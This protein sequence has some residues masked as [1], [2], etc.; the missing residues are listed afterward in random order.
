[1]VGCQDS[2]EGRHKIGTPGPWKVCSRHSLFL[3]KRMKK[4]NQDHYINAGKRHAKFPTVFY[5]FKLTY[6]DKSMRTSQKLFAIIF[7]VPNCC[8]RETKIDSGTS[9]FPGR[10]HFQHSCHYT[11]LCQYLSQIAKEKTRMESPAYVKIAAVICHS[12]S[13]NFINLYKFPQKKPSV[14]VWER[15]IKVNFCSLLA[16]KSLFVFYSYNFYSNKHYWT[17]ESSCS[18]LATQSPWWQYQH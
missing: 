8:F 16:A 14:C 12:Q 18:P 7:T 10:S 15:W 9:C 3:Q 11:V 1:M 6:N 4:L 2:V 17:E 5:I 13:E